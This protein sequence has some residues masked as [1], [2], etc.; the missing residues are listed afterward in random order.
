MEINVKTT[1]AVL[2]LLL[3]FSCAVK[4]EDD[5]PVEPPAG[6][7]DVSFTFSTESVVSRTVLG[8][9]RSIL[10][11]EGDAVS[12]F[13]GSANQKF[14][15]VEAGASVAFSGEAAAASEYYALYP[16]D[17]SAG[18]DGSVISTVIPSR[19][20]GVRDG[21]DPSAQLMT[22]HTE[23]RSFLMKNVV[24][25]VKLNIPSGVAS[26]KLVSRSGQKIAGRVSITVGEDGIPTSISAET[27]SILLI[28]EGE[29]FDAGYYYL[30]TAPGI[31]TAGLEVIL[32]KSGDNKQYV[33]TSTNPCPF[34]RSE[35]T[36]LLIAEDKFV[37]VDPSADQMPDFSRVGYHY[38]DREI[39]DVPV[40]ITLSPPS[41][42]D[43]DSWD[44]IQNAINT[45]PTPGAILLT[46]GTYKVSK[47]LKLTRSGVV[48]RG[49]GV[50]TSIYCTATEQIPN[51]IQIG[52]VISKT[53]STYSDITAQYVP[54][55]QMW[56]P[57]QDPSVF[58]VGDHVFLYRPA[59]ENWLD[60]IHMREIPMNASGTT[61]Q[62]T[63][64][65]Y[66]M[67][68]DRIVTAIEGDK[69]YLD[70]PVVMGIGTPEG[71]SGDWGTGR[72]YKGSWPRVMECG[73]ENMIL[74]TRYDPS[75]VDEE[76]NY[77]DEEHAWSAV[78]VYAAQHC[79]VAHVTTRS[80][81]YCCVNLRGGSKNITVWDCHSTAPVSQITGSRRYAFHIYFGELCLVKDCTCEYDRHQFV[82]GARVPGPSVFHNCTATNTR[83]DTQAGPH[84]RWATGILWDN[85]VS[86]ARI[87]IQDRCWSGSGHGWTGVNCVLY[88]CEAPRLVCQSP[89]ASGQNWAIG[90]IGE[91]W[92]HTW[93]YWNTPLGDNNRPD[94]IWISPG[95]H[96]TPESLWAHQITER[97]AAG[98]NLSTLMVDDGD[99][100]TGTE[101]FSPSDDYS[102]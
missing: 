92:D 99:G 35:V 58:A 67:Y 73:V 97:H 90:C 76:G 43:E 83:S 61:T 85:V 23:G 14:T 53:L 75:L 47:G 28:P 16:Y 11:S 44:M 20:K 82:T 13:A 56:V 91:K 6:G 69:I 30:A 52:N 68:W 1:V 24:A 55:G 42:P 59:T 32:T 50:A 86:D 100:N 37:P 38:G 71:V 74:D 9:D 62:W 39:P 5:I 72:L 17:A 65:A 25:L 80:F 3:M 60:A 8:E 36:S 66:K 88:N 7:K 19:Q 48:L 2:S 63:P 18:I 4:P 41:N 98:I 51:L 87:E 79:W 34:N 21:F 45:V 49:E 15:A 46:A 26:V 84:Q 64:A 78:E 77:I 93:D 101:A 22:G 102:F 94:G 31:Q 33:A 10:W 81:G 40:K 95:E 89:W 27:S 29:T 12:I 96:V 54:C 57:V 70:N